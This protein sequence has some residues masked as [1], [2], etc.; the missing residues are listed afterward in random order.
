[1]QRKSD[2][3]Q[4]EIENWRAS[5]NTGASGTEITNHH[6]I[7]NDKIKFNL[8]YVKNNFVKVLSLHASK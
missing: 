1:M 7:E 5:L 4:N 6:N 2:V 8:K 3:F